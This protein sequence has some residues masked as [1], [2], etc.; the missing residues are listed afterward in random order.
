[1]EKKEKGGM[2]A[3]FDW[4]GWVGEKREI[5]VLTRGCTHWSGTR[6]LWLDKHFL[7]LGSL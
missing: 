5:E 6:N 3:S 7:T 4:G 1:M 2:A